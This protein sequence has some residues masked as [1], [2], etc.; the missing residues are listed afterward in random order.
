MKKTYKLEA[1]FDFEITLSIDTDLMSAQ[2]A[3][4][5]TDFAGVSAFMLSQSDDDLYQV[6]ARMAAAPL[7]MSLVSGYTPYAALSYLEDS[8]GWPAALST[9]L[10]IKDY[11][12]PDLDP[13]Y[14]IVEEL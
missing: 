11:I 8:E 2:L 14:L 13:E 4:D 12:I 3:K 1:G 10:T 9:M 5:I 7:L 6:V